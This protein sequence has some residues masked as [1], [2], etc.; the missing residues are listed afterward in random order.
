MKAK[1]F[2]EPNSRCANRY[3]DTEMSKINYSSDIS[4]PNSIETGAK[5]SECRTC[6]TVGCVTS[7]KLYFESNSRGANEYKDIEMA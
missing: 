2:F 3:K 1:P 7:A 6:F 5:S 4:R